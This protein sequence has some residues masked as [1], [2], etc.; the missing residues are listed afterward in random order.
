MTIGKDPDAVDAETPT[1]H[2]VAAALGFD[3]VD[4]H[5][6]TDPTADD[7][8][9]ELPSRV[10]MW[11][12]IQELVQTIDCLEERVDELQQE[13]NR[14]DRNRKEIASQLHEITE[15]VAETDE[16]ADQAKEIAKTA[17]ANAEQ[18]KSIAETG[19]TA[20][21]REDPEELPGG[22]EPSSSPLD[23]LANCRQHRVKKHL[24]DQGTPRKN[25]FRALLVM[26]RWDE[27]ATKRTNGSGIFWTRDDVRDALTA[28]LGK[29]PHAQT[30]KRVWNEMIA[31]GSSDIDVTERRVS[32]KQTPK[33]IIAMDIETAEGLFESRYHHLEL[34]DSDGQV[35]GGVTP[36]V[37]QND[38]AKV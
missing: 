37:T 5:T 16:T 28:I 10:E 13:Q 31:I 9:D 17:N 30:L 36:V 12:I 33:E 4:T 2:D 15:S 21:D 18:A 20:F 24:V 3:S 11:A 19:E 26:K 25:R 34:L 6:S 27:F 1:N 8:D 22:I 35:T 7:G 38:R 14:A 23:F 29:R 32:A